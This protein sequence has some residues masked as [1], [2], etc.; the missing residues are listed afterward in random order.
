MK[1]HIL[2]INI[3]VLILLSI[4][5][6]PRRV[7]HAVIYGHNSKYTNIYIKDKAEQIKLPTKCKVGTVINYKYNFF[8]ILDFSEVKPIKE[9]VLIKNKNFYDLEKTGKI[10]L[11]KSPTYYYLK[12]NT[13]SVCTAKNLILGKYNVK[14]Y[15]DEK[16]NLNTFII[17]PEDYS[18]M[19]VGISNSNFKSIYHNKIQLTTLDECSLYSLKDNFYLNIPKNCKIDIFNTTTSINVKINNTTKSFKNRIYIKGNRIKTNSI[20]RGNPKFTPIYSGILELYQM[21]N[22]IV[23][24]N[25]VSLEDYISKVVP[26]EMPSFGGVEALKCQAIAARTYAISDMLANRFSHLGFY[27]DD[28]TQSQ[29]Y[30]NTETNSLSEEAV[31][32]TKGLIMTYKNIPIDAKYYSSS[33][34]TA[35]SYKDIWFK[36]DGSSDNKPYYYKGSYIKSL[37]TLPNTEKSWLEFYKNTDLESIDKS[38]PYFRWNI[39]FPKNVLEKSLKKSLY[40]NY[41][42]RKDFIS[43]SHNKKTNSMPE[44]KTLKD[45]QV[46]KRGAAGNVIEISFIFSNATINVKGDLNIRS[47]IICSK[48]FTG[49]IIP[50]L[51]YKKEPLINNKFLP[52]SFFSIEKIHNKFKIWGGGYGHGVGMSQFGAMEL[53]KQGIKY[54]DI[55]KTFY[56]DIKIKNIY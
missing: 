53:S 29:V 31:N 32:S 34:G 19:R 10:L 43:I 44:L 9:R 27:V 4:L 38:S 18:Y 7:E 11:S 16:N 17:T 46:K 2:I 8:K 45:I 39:E 48:D 20:S 56:K 12:D 30:N 37:N 3:L 36:S 33:A 42:K 47:S 1:K 35:A 28:S 55:L 40:N 49:V 51:R 5:F 14:N 25:E 15:L 54:T 22:G 23:L 41:E 26:S 50:I 52:S 21:S 6:L 24:I 13:I